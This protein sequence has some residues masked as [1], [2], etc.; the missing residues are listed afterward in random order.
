MSPVPDHPLT[1]GGTTTPPRR[2]PVARLAAVLA[3]AGAAPTPREIAELVW[4][5]GRLDDVTLLSATP[6]SWWCSASRGPS[7]P[8]PAREDQRL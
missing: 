7:M 4:L 5:A 8:R 2:S 3:A 1:P 6:G